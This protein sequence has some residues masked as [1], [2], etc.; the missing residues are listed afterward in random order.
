MS[1]PPD[2]SAPRLADHHAHD[3]AAR[4]TSD[5]AATDHGSSGRRR[6]GGCPPSAPLRR[7]PARRDRS[8]AS[9]MSRSRRF[10]S[11]SR[12]RRSSA[13]TR[14]GRRRAGSAVQS[15]SRSRIA[16]SV[17][18]TRLAG[19][20]APPGQHLV[21]HA[22]ERPDVGAL[23]DR[24]AR[25]PARGSCRRPCR[26]S[27]RRA[28]VAASDRS[29]TASRSPCAS[30]VERPCE[31]EVEHLDGAVGRDLDVGRLQI[32]MDDALLV[33]G[34]ERLG[35]LTRDR[36]RLADRRPA[37]ARCAR[38]ASSPS[39]SSITSAVT[40]SAV[41]EA[42]DRA[43]C[44]DGSARRAFALRARTARAVPASRGERLPAGP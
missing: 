5:A 2:V 17:S 23:V 1:A 44:A 39:T 26:G 21:E 31:T 25:A 38:R 27:R 9:P 20:R 42:V 18:D 11:F 14:G 7:R 33:R 36:E 10:G 24:L 28:S 35:N 29:A 4:L 30:V 3:V 8:R 22:A 34:F 40:S 19:E 43:R 15:G 12:H 6:A 37:R 41:F 16:A 32:A 13:R